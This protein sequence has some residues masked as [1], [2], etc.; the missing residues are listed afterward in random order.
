LKCEPQLNETNAV[1]HLFRRN[2][3]WTSG[4]KPVNDHIPMTG[5]R[6]A[7][8]NQ[9]LIFKF[10][11]TPQ[12]LSIFVNAFPEHAL[13]CCNTASTIV[14]YFAYRAPPNRMRVTKVP[15]F[16]MPFAPDIH[17]ARFAIS[18]VDDFAHVLST[19][20]LERVE[21]GCQHNEHWMQNDGNSDESKHKHNY[22]N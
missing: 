2:S 14:M 15:V 5:F 8:A 17:I 4:C 1:R 16:P 11:H 7:E 22:R 18:D 19:E 13:E 10:T 21:A 3:Q 20:R 12:I 6:L 9:P